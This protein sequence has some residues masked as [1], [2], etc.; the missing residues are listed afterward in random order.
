MLDK[1][2][3]YIANYLW[4]ESITNVNLILSDEEKK[5]FNVADYYYLSAIHFMEHPNSSDIAKELSLTKPAISAL[6]KRLEAS[7]MIV[8]KQS[9]QDK[10][11]FYLALSDKGKAVI[12]GDALIYNT[13]TNHIKAL[14]T[15]EQMQE[16]SCLMQGIVTALQAEK[17]RNVKK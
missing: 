7:G 11:V 12:E 16:I 4:R 1:N 15:P 8:K 14:V 3:A 10:R 6:I 13:F 2:F 5:K 17:E 9:N